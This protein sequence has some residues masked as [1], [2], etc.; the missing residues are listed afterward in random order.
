[1]CVAIGLVAEW[2]THASPLRFGTADAQESERIVDFQS[3]IV[4]AEDGPLTVTETI[5]V[6]A[7]GDQIKHGIYRDF[8]TRYRG[9]WFTDVVVPFEVASVHRNGDSEQFHTSEG[10]RS[11]RVYMGDEA[12]MLS[13]G[14]HTYTLVYRTARQLGFFDDHDELYWNVT[15]N[16]WVFPIDHVSATVV[17]PAA[18]PRQQVTLEGYTGPEG[19][20][21]RNLRAE[22]DSGTGELHFATTVALAPHEGL[23]IVA[24]FPKGFIQ[25]PSAATRRAELMR[26]NP[27]LVTGAIGLL[28]VV[29]YYLLAWLVVGRDPAQG[30][31]IPLFEPPLGLDPPGLRFVAGMG[32]DERCL[33]A[34][35]VSLAVKGWVRIEEEDGEFSLIA[36]KDRHTAL[37]PAERRVNT[38]LLSTGHFELKQKHHSALRAAIRA[39]R[40][41]LRREY[42]GTMFRANRRWVIPGLVL[43]ALAILVAGFSGSLGRSLQFGFMLVWL[44]GWTFACFHLGTNVWR[45]WRAV[46][47]PGASAMSRIGSGIIATLATAIAIPFFFAEAFA[48]GM[49]VHASSVWMAP[50]LVCL[51]GVNFLFY[52]LLKQPTLA[53]RKVMDQIEGFR[54][55][56]GTAEGAEL[57]Q[58]APA[59]TP[60]L[61]ERLLPFAIALGVENQWAEQFA[62]VL[63]DAVQDG[64]SGA[65]PTW[66]RGNAFSGIGTM[67]FASAL[68]ASLASSI[69]S[70]S[71]APGSRSGSSGGGSSGGGGGGGGGGGW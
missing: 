26:S 53:G 17:L 57:A 20:T 13:P 49:L 42:D 27:V 71:S 47:R 36:L 69:A 3:R 11:L 58:A 7:T 23:T 35:L 5:T 40:E 38:A 41:A 4:V 54:M 70:S 9:P 25:P 55:Y 14:R 22:L 16:G 66:Y 29:L 44:T 56:L 31:I 19:S 34:A 30:T 48:L 65:Q 21:D 46:V 2:A 59:K 1:M 52:Y 32:Y 6:D 15:G 61:Y 12:A 50:V 18:I 64:N 68:N 10:E 33:T 45:G 39:L 51:V 43:S 37:G 67:G 62:A 63:S 8:P 24:S 28:A 60:Q